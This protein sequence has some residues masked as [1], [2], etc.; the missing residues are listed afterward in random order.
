MYSR[1]SRSLNYH[2]ALYHMSLVSKDYKVQ[3]HVLEEKNWSSLV[4]EYNT[5][6]EKLATV[7]TNLLSA[8]PVFGQDIV[9]LIWK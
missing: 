8:I 5:M 9:E 1:I 3:G 6:I 7:I 2:K 4:F